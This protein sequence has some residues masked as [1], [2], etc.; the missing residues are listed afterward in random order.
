MYEEY[1]VTDNSSPK[2]VSALLME[3][4]VRSA[5]LQKSIQEN[6]RNQPNIGETDIID[7]T[8]K[9]TCTVCVLSLIHI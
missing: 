7:V 6:K 3:L 8:H 4:V 1:T 9:P 2:S 5:Q